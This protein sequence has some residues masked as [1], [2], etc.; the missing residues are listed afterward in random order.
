MSGAPRGRSG[1]ARPATGNEGV[2]IGP[3][4]LGMVMATLCALAVRA[5]ADCPITLDGD[6]E[7]IDRVRAELGRFADGSA[8]CVA[9]WV[10]CRQNGTELE[11]DLHDELGRSSL[12]LFMSASGAAAFLI[13]WSRRPLPEHGPDAPPGLVEPRLPP[14]PAA[15]PSQDLGWHPEFSLAYVGASGSH[16]PWGTITAAA[17][18]DARIWRYG[19]GGRV[20]TGDIGAVLTIGV[21]AA[22]GVQTALMPRVTAAAELFAGD[23]VVVRNNSVGGETNYGDAG[24]RGGIRARIVWRFTD[25]LGFELHWGYDVVQ[26]PPYAQNPGWQTLGNVG[27]GLRWLP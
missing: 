13:S 12:H 26:S 18:K 11:I 9:L 20:I 23:G 14:S 10:Q 17:M 25:S 27:L 3:R 24:L 22:L 4:T 21:E 2:M 19:G 5:Q 16:T 15:M 7:V 6:A 1:E 8:P